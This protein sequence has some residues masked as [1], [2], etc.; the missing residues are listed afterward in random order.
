MTEYQKGIVVDVDVVDGERIYTFG[1]GSEKR[2]SGP[3]GYEEYKIEESMS[4]E[5]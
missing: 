3:V 1:D 2:F 5:E 4:E